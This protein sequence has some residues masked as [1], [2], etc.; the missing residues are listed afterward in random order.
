MLNN[1]YIDKH[2]RTPAEG[3][4]NARARDEKGKHLSGLTLFGRRRRRRLADGL[5]EIR[6]SH[7]TPAQ[8]S[9]DLGP[10]ARALL[11][12][13]EISSRTPS[14][15]PRPRESE[16]KCRASPRALDDPSIVLRSRGHDLVPPGAWHAPPKIDCVRVVRWRRRP[17]AAAAASLV[18]TSSFSFFLCE[19]FER[20]CLRKRWYCV[21]K[22]GCD[23]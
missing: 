1:F 19:S 9:P 23:K 17:L 13:R 6:A 16:K 7:H 18:G 22:R 4:P 11:S 20:S 21:R 3:R 2:A 5:A 10:L 14:T 12:T 15:V 8:R